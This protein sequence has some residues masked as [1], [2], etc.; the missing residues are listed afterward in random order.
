MLSGKL[1]LCGDDDS[2]LKSQIFKLTVRI[3]ILESDIPEPNEG[4]DTSKGGKQKLSVFEEELEEKLKTYESKL[5]TNA[6]LRKDLTKVREELNQFLKWT[7]LFKII[8]NL[9]G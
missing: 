7:D 1:S 9:S 5:V 6:Q 4:P 3:S 8:S 2:A